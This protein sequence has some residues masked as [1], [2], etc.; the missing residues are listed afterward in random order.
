MVPCGTLGA[1]KTPTTRPHG[2]LSTAEQLRSLR[3]A[4][5]DFAEKAR[6]SYSH[7]SGAVPIIAEEILNQVDAMRAYLNKQIEDRE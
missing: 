2:P 7:G 6:W 5:N 1:M 3:S 4:L